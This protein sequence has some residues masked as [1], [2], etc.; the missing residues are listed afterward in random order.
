MTSTPSATPVSVT[1]TAA[2]ATWEPVKPQ[3]SSTPRTP[4]LPASPETRLRLVAWLSVTTMP[5]RSISPPLVTVTF[6]LIVSPGGTTVVH[7][8][9]TSM[10][11]V[12]AGTVASA[13]PLGAGG[14]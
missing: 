2:G 10:A 13:A 3:V 11:Q 14:G 7:S 1:D 5:V 4:S 8:L 12:T 9:V 6:T